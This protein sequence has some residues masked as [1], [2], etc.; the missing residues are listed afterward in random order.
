[1]ESKGIELVLG[2]IECMRQTRLLPCPLEGSDTATRSQVLVESILV[3][4]IEAALT[5]WNHAWPQTWCCVLG[6]AA[7]LPETVHHMTTV[8]LAQPDAPTCTRASETG[9]KRQQTL[10]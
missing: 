6:G 2:L 9:S 4:S 5:Y 3:E 8:L 1:M 10:N 7:A